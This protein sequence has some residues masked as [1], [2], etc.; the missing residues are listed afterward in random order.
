VSVRT[1][2]VTSKP[3]ARSNADS[4]SCSILSRAPAPSNTTL[5]LFKYVHTS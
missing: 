1:N 4:S 3:N 2:V 5:P